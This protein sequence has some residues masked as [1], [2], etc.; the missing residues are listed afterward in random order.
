MKFLT[1][2]F[3][4][5]FTAC[6]FSKNKKIETAPKTFIEKPR[7][8]ILT[9]DDLMVLSK[10]KA[11]KKYGK[12]LEYEKFILTNGPLE[13]RIE[14][15]NIY[16]KEEILN[17]TIKIEELTWEKD[18]LNFVTAWYESTDSTSIPKDIYVWEKGTE[19]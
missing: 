2:F 15:L 7:Q 16:T 8:Q 10:T 11:I 19:F 4:V 18:S 13:F 1:L 9:F 3:I 6:D 17:N 14:L 12:P 5:A